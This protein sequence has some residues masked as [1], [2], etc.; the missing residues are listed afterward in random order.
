MYFYSFTGFTPYSPSKAAI[1]ALSDSLSQEINL[2][3]AAHPDLPRV[4]VHTVFPAIIPTQSLDYENLLKT[5]LT[6]SFEEADQ[7]LKPE[8]C[9]QQ[10]I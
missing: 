5:D 10:A 4:R 2:Y 6:K 9:A 7:I 1:R 8:D 3:A